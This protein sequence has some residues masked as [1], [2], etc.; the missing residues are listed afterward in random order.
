MSGPGL[1]NGRTGSSSRERSGANGSITRQ[2]PSCTGTWT[3]SGRLQCSAATCARNSA[4][5]RWL[6][7]PTCSGA[8]IGRSPPQHTGSSHAGPSGVRPRASSR[9]FSRI[10]ASSPGPQDSTTPVTDGIPRP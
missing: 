3:V 2:A 1:W 10:T 9:P 8:V 6:I 5:G 7:A 4:R